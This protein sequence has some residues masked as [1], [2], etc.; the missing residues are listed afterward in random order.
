MTGG[1]WR[2]AS[3]IVLSVLVPLAL[4][5]LRLD[6]AAAALGHARRA[7]QAA[8]RDREAARVLTAAFLA[9][10]QQD[11]AR[12]V[13]PA[14][15]QRGGTPIWGWILRSSTFATIGMPDSARLAL[16]SARA[17]AS[18]DPV[19]EADLRAP[20]DLGQQFKAAPSAR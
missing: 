20:S 2:S 3:D 15:L 4:V 9:L 18:R 17:H 14:F 19:T 16:D 1:P 7:V 5:L 8:P 11:S 6:S 13:W 10:H 12:A